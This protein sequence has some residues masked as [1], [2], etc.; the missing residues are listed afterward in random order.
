[1]PIPD[2][3]ADRPYGPLCTHPVAGTIVLA[4]AYWGLSHLAWMI[5]HALGV[6]PL[7]V[8]P[9]AGLAF[10]AAL[11][12][13]WWAAPGLALGTVLANQVS[14]GAPWGLAASIAIMNSVGPVLGAVLLRWRVTR[15]LQIHSVADLLVCLGIMLVLV[16]LLTASGGI[17]A[18][19]LLG[20]TAAPEMPIQ[21]A[22]W[23]VAHALG[24]LLIGVPLL[25]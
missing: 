19:W 13:G 12:G 16:P 15:H 20:L 10:A 8:W 25:I 24:T 5:F 9:A 17:G 7:P 4:L 14:L 21:M 22:R 6:L 2:T 1:M 11:H 23:A 18:K 3:G